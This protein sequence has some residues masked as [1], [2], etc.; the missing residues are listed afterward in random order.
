M[1]M[2]PERWRRLRMLMTQ[3][4][5]L[6]GPR[7]GLDIFFQELDLFIRQSGI[8]ALEAEVQF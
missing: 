1:V 3:Q 6:A 8:S 7:F 2:L 4:V 5:L